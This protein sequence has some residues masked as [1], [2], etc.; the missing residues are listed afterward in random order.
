MIKNK[1]ISEIAYSNILTRLSKLEALLVQKQ[2]GSDDYFLDNQEF[3]QLMNISKRTAQTW[4]DTG[5]IPYSQVGNK[6][7]YHMRDIKAL[8][9]HH[10]RATENLQY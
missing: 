8:L 6:V 5:T 7:Y 1:Y 3:L 2:S 10:Y 9:K 4:R